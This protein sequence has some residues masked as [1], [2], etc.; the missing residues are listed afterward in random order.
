MINFL[1]YNIKNILDIGANIGE[2]SLYMSRLFPK[3]Y[4]LMVE[5]NLSCKSDLQKL[6]FN[7]EIALLSDSNKWIDFYINKN[8]I[9]STGNSYYLEN[10]KYFEN[11]ITKKIYSYTLDEI[12]KKYDKDFDF[13]KIDTQGS[14]LDILRGGLNTISK[15]KFIM[16]ECSTI[17]EKLYNKGSYHIDEIIDFME[18]NN[19]K[20]YFTVEEHLWWEKNPEIAPYSY[21]E[22]FQKDLLFVAD[23]I[24]KK[25]KMRQKPTFSYS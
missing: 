9:K 7:Y 15:S 3:A 6:P 23:N 14:E 8:N 19:F 5:A 24:S 13:I 16:I 12:A 21:G 17:K 2:F 18:K 25:L 11:Y 10:T 20:K 1:N 4:I 22:V